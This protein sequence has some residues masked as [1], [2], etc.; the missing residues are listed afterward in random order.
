MRSQSLQYIDF[1]DFK[2][3]CQ[4]ICTSHIMTGICGGGG[5]HCILLVGLDSGL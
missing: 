3:K 4:Y 5:K 2:L 1:I